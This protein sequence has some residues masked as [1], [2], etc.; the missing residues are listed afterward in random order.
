M[1][2]AAKDPG[3]P[4]RSLAFGTARDGTPHL[5]TVILREAVPDTR[6]LAF[7]S[8][9]RAQKIDDI[10]S[11]DCVAWMGWDP[12][13]AEQVRLRGTAT[14]HVEDAV[15]EA[16]W[17]AEAP[18]S[19]DIYVRPSA[20]GTP[21]DAPDDGL[22]PSVSTEPV[23]REDVADGWPYF[24]VIRTVVDE[25]EWLHLHPDGHYRARFR[26]DPDAEAFEGTWVVP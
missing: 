7:H 17:E 21:L 9:R 15:A 10:R 23:T 11:S 16:M 24:A 4:Y 22:D 5:R 18:S 8:D 1:S 13:T 2:T 6:R 25:M 26:Y 3:H 14:V 19:L 12:E 20:P